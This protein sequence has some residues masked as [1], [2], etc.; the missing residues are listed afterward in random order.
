ME[1]YRS[2]LS[3]PPAINFGPLKSPHL[4]LQEPLQAHLQA[5]VLKKGF[6]LFSE[7]E[8]ECLIKRFPKICEAAGY[9][10]SG[11]SR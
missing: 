9:Q 11:K 3:R 8:T 2:F 5:G 7:R 6:R 1:L 10:P 4:N